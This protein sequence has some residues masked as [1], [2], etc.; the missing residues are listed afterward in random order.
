VKLLMWLS[1]FPIK[2]VGLFTGLEVYASD[3]AYNDLKVRYEF[4][5]T[6][7]NDLKMARRQLITSWMKLVVFWSVILWFLHLLIE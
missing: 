5:K 2:A 4:D 6:L 3:A 7:E 1:E